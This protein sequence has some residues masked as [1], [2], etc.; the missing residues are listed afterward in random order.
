MKMMR[1]SKKILIFLTLSVSLILQGFVSTESNLPF[2]G[3]NP[4]LGI[5]YDG[6]PL[7]QPISF[8]TLQ[9]VGQPQL[10]VSKTIPVNDFVQS[11][12]DGNANTIRGLYVDNKFAFPVVQQPSGKAGFV[13]TTEDVITDF[14][15]PKKYGVTGLLAHNYLA[16]KEFF[17][18]EIG[19]LIQVVYG[20]GSVQMYR[21]SD[22]QSYQAL[23]P[24]SA[25][26]NFVDLATSEKLSA[27]QLFK[28]VY[29]GEHHLTLQTCIQQGS[30]DS[31]GRL[32]VIADPV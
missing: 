8:D 26:S 16:G 4:G 19:D 9:D 10:Q 5:A 23:S 7:A 14:G 28:R 15:M 27:T 21:I 1:V 31:W 22:I 24:N 25:S 32:F 2:S 20:D 18:L 29:M 6:L 30:E 3:E 11:L 12:V 17:E 13:S